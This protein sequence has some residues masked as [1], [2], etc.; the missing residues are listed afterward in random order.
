MWA[1]SESFPN[2]ESRDAA[3]L[4]RDLRHRKIDPTITPPDISNQLPARLQ[5]DREWAARMA[6]VEYALGKP[7]DFQGTGNVLV[8]TDGERKEID[9]APVLSKVMSS[10]VDSLLKDLTGESRGAA[11]TDSTAWLKT[12][13]AQ[14]DR[15]PVS[16]L[17]A[18]RVEIK[19]ESNQAAVQ[20]A[21]AAR[22]PNGSWE[23]VWSHREA[24]DSTKPRADMEAKISEDPQVKQVLSTV[25]S[26]GL[27]ADDQVRQAIRFGA[28]TMT[29]QQ[30]ADARFFEFRDRYLKRLDGPPL[31]WTK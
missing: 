6:I 24:Q 29:A 8:R 22:M 4:E 13:S 12:V 21:F 25:K 15:I 5:D 27:N 30:T 3:D 2:V 28:A 19:V 9:L 17:R 23:I 14:A 11:P 1:W 16:G 10:Q 26:F 7:L 18:T 31:T 20:S